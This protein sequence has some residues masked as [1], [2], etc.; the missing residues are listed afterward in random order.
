MG[1][2]DSYRNAFQRKNQE[3]VK[4]QQDKAREQKTLA[5]KSVKINNA[6]QAINRI[7]ST[8]TINSKLREIARLEKESASLTSKIAGIETKISKKQ[9]ELADVQKNIDREELRE[10][11]KRKQET[12]RQLREQERNFQSI[13]TTLNEHGKLHLETLNAI[14]QIRKIPEKIVVLFLASNP[15]DQVQ[16]RLDEEA[17]SIT[18]MIT[19]SKH[20]DS[21]RF[22]TCWA[23]QPKDVLQA[24]N[25]YNP[26][27][28]H[29]SG[30][31]S[32][33]DEIIFQTNNGTAKVVS[34]EAIVQ[35]M[36]A[37]SE[38]IRLV[39][40]NTCYS[41]NQAEAVVEHVEA[42]IGMNTSI[43]DE[44]ALIF[45]SQF[46][47][48]IGFG[49]SIDKA[50]EQAKALL[51]LEGIPEED[52]PELFIHD[53]LDSKKIVIVKPKDK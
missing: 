30:H 29:F 36:M 1:L 10:S 27:I 11:K 31:G 35:T 44:A 37:S 14:E 42:A 24:I 53:G 7:K 2:L 17:R 49:L 9:K 33:N 16:L 20:R 21:I 26:S 48:A 12:E 32:D 3:L 51:I 50:F 8:S 28:V 18:E 45:S 38:E 15:I 34:K 47:S 25:E 43:G 19:K 52:T 5:D 22:Q 6:S 46:Y 23:V 4:L 40:F 39:F 13:N 41:R